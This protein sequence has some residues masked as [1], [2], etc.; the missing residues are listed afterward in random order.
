MDDK[1][2]RGSDQVTVL[3]H[4]N[5]TNIKKKKNVL[6]ESERPAVAAVVLGCTFRQLFLSSA[7][8]SRGQRGLQTVLEDFF[9]PVTAFLECSRCK[10]LLSKMLMMGRK[11]KGG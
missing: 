6:D 9:L 2:Q 4:I 11:Q 7:K 1:I 10:Q 8:T 3:L 5:I